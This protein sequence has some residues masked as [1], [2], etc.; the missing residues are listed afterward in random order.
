MNKKTLIILAWVAVIGFSYWYWK[1]K[2]VPKQQAALAA[3]Q[4]PSTP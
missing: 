1:Y 4:T 2:I 3:S